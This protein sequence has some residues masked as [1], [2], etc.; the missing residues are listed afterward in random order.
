MIVLARIKESAFMSTRR[1]DTS[2]WRMLALAFVLFALT[3]RAALPFG[4]SVVTN[5]DGIPMVICSQIAQIQAQFDNESGD[6]VPPASQGYQCPFCMVLS[7]DGAPLPVVDSADFGKPV[8]EIAVVI[9]IRSSDRATQSHLYHDN[10][11]R[12]P[13]VA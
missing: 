6:A 10:I 3:L 8:V 11:G 2:P 12:D 1:V 7:A 9:P 13:P 4:L 5:D